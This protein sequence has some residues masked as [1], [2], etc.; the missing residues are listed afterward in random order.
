MINNNICQLNYGNGETGRIS[1][2]NLETK[3]FETDKCKLWN[4]PKCN[5][6][7]CKLKNEIELVQ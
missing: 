7:S 5:V 3:V 2:Y 1:K 6:I 4:N